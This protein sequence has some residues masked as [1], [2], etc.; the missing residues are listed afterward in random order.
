MDIEEKYEKLLDRYCKLFNEHDELTNKMNV[1]TMNIGEC[2]TVIHH[3][4]A[5]IES[6]KCCGNCENQ[7]KGQCTLGD[8]LND[9]FPVETSGKCE[10]WQPKAPEKE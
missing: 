7:D 6:L 10:D 3:Q 4:K 2:Q 5:E 1:L 9:S 8:E